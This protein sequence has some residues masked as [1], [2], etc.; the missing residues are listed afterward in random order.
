MTL[1]RNIPL[2]KFIKKWDVFSLNRSVKKNWPVYWALG[3][4]IKNTSNDRRKFEVLLPFNSKTR[5]YF[6][7][8]F[9]GALFA[10]VDP[11]HVF[12]ISL[13]LGSD[14][15]VWDT[16]SEIKFLK[17]ASEDVVAEIKIN[18]KEINTIKEQCRLN[19]KSTRDY[20]IDI[21][22][23][24]GKLVATVFKS[25]YIRIKNPNLERKMR[26]T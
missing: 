23:V 16:S 14:Y 4:R 19:K 10:F 6:G 2:L 15:M 11:I 13:N 8:H 9:G 3:A 17:A 22:T 7:T 5:G 18:Q 21:K 1:T 25:V 12:A 24:S 20:R 26:S